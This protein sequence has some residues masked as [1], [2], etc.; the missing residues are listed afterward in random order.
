MNVRLHIEELVL[1]GF[2]PGDR[3]RIAAAVEVELTRLLTERGVPPGLAS[4][5]AVPSLDGGSFGVAPEARPDRI[6]AQVAQS[7]YGG[8]SR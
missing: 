8:M 7:V 6:G 4:G 1:D 2:P 5:G 3:Y